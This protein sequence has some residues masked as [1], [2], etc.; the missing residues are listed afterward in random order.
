MLMLAFVTAHALRE[1][2]VQSP[3]IVRVAALLK[4]TLP[5]E[6]TTKLKNVYAEAAGNAPFPLAPVCSSVPAEDAKLL[7][8]KSW[9]TVKMPPLWVFVPAPVKSLPPMKVPPLC[10]KVPL[11]AK[12]PTSASVPPWTVSDPPA[13][14]VMDFA[15]RFW[16]ATTIG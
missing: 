5:P 14:I 10:V 9:S 1:S 4:T 13:L 16:S 11:F 8:L 15:V 2:F 7:G 6:S 3:R 12:F